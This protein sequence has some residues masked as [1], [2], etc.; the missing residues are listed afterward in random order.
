MNHQAASYYA[1]YAANNGMTPEQMSAHDRQRYPGGRN[2]GF[3]L[4]ISSQWQAWAKANGR[5]RHAPKA[6]SDHASFAQ[7]IGA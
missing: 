1:A 2:A 3:I 4:W 5:N 7:F 6:P